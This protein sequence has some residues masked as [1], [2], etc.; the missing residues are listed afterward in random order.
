M[1][2][3]EYSSYFSTIISRRDDEQVAPYDKPAYIEYTRLN[4][5]RMQ[6]WLKPDNLTNELKAAVANITTAQ[7]WIIITEPWCGDAAHNVPF[8]QKA[9]ALN[10]LINVTYELRDSEP[11]RI[12]QYLTNGGKSIPKLIIRDAQGH[13]LATWGPR[14][15]QCR[16][17]SKTR[18]GESSFRYRECADPDLV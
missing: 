1:T 17:V 6:R 11:F 7:Q 18:G 14:P 3:E 12:N 5:T 15:A 8:L 9:A 4:W 16:I 2:F 13:D 10:P